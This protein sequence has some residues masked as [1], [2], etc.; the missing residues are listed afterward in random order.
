ML[1][2]PPQNSDTVGT[3]ADNP[4]PQ[5]LGACRLPIP[6][7]VRGFTLGWDFDSH[8]QKGAR[9]PVASI[10]VGESIETYTEMD[11]MRNPGLL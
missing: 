9:C 10:F 6:Q 2:L 4:L 11:G 5:S 7:G 8:P 3:G 1:G